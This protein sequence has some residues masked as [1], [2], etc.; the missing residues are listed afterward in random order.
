MSPDGDGGW[1]RLTGTV[2]IAGGAT[3]IGRAALEMFRTAG[4]DLLL[5][6]IDATLGPVFGRFHPGQSRSQIQPAQGRIGACLA[7]PSF[8]YA[9]QALF[10]LLE[11][12]DLIS[13]GPATLPYP[14]ALPRLEPGFSYCGAVLGI[15]WTARHA[16]EV[17]P[18]R[19]SV[20]NRMIRR[21]RFAFC[22]FLVI[23]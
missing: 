19:R 16:Q 17:M 12:Q 22:S 15:I 3:G 2:L 8:E 20:K 23:F 5:A 10:D 13:D 7:M 14:T 1:G 9:G 21:E 18:W 6:D 4:D 11:W